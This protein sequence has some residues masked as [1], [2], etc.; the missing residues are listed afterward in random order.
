MRLSA[1]PTT[2]SLKDMWGN[3]TVPVPR[4]EVLFGRVHAESF[5]LYITVPPHC[6][7]SSFAVRSQCPHSAHSA[8]TAPPTA[9]TVPSTALT[10]V[11]QCLH[12]ADTVRFTVITG[13]LAGEK[14]PTAQL[15]TVQQLLEPRPPR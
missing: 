4:F 10:V 3:Y 9:L 13:T 2:S 7:Q 6:V 8:F 11:S 14:C 5:R 1:S 12:N 15:Q